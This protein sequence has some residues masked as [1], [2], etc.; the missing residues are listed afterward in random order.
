MPLVPEG[1]R[2]GEDP[3]LGSRTFRYK[4]LFSGLTVIC[5]LAEVLS[6]FFASPPYWPQIL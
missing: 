5:V 4:P 3:P 2:E 6:P 1:T